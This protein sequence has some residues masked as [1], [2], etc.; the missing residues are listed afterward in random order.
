MID[1]EQVGDYAKVGGLLAG[2]V[3]AAFRSRGWIK[4]TTAKD[5]VEIASD[6]AYVDMLK[7][8]MDEADY[9]RKRADTA[10]DQRNVA[11]TT[12]GEVR[13]EMAGIKQMHV[14]C[15]RRILALEGEVASLRA[16]VDRRLTPRE[17]D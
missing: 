8:A 11:I 4:R 9:Q 6:D 14:D 5:G 2:L 3:Y 15:E 12:L 7:R 10:F 13:G 1:W 17:S 16:I